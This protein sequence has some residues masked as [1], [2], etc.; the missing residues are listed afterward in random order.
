LLL[1]D[2]YEK[3]GEFADSGNREDMVTE[4]KDIGTG[5]KTMTGRNNCN[6]S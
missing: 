5:H 6:K 1:L 4:K 3:N 2:K